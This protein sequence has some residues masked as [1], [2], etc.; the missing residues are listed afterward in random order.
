MG[1]VVQEYTHHVFLCI[2]NEYQV[3]VLIIRYHNGVV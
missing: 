2:M 3:C 1:T